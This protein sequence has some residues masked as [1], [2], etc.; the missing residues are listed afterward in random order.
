MGGETFH[1]RNFLIAWA[2]A[3]S[4]NVGANFLMILGMKRGKM[5]DT[6]PFLSLSPVFLLVSGYFL[7]GELADGRGMV[8][9]GVIAA[10][11]FWL[12]RAGAKEGGDAASGAAQEKGKSF[13]SALP[14]GAGIYIFIAMIQSVSSA[15]DKRGVRAAPSPILYGA[16]ISATVAVFALLKFSWQVWKDSGEHAVHSPA[17]VPAAANGEKPEQSS[18]RQEAQQKPTM[19]R[20]RSSGFQADLMSSDIWEKLEV[21]EPPSRQTT[22][23]ED[24]DSSGLSD[25]DQSAPDP[26]PKAAAAPQG[27]VIKRRSSFAGCDVFENVADTIAR[28]TSK[29]GQQTSGANKMGHERSR[30]MIRRKSSMF[31]APL[32]ELEENE[33]EE[34]EPKAKK[35]AATSFAKRWGLMLLACALKMTAYWCQLKANERIFSSHLS[36]IRKSGVLLVMLLGKVLFNEEIGSKMMPVGTMLVGVAILAAK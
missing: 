15:F 4:I 23:D 3:G 32:A 31:M 19:M 17:S 6:V 1:D 25:E 16:T 8:G 21:L 20:R 9:V 24:D 33:A 12:S 34:V 2:V 7:L 14:P 13:L 27:P 22:K 10:G 29:S 30:Q 36:A 11:G 26:K 18:Q 28:P 35:Q 5:S